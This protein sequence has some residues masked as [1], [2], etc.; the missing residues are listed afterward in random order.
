MAAPTIC[1][2]IKTSTIYQLGNYKP[3][4]IISCSLENTNFMRTAL[5]PLGVLEVVIRNLSFLALMLSVLGITIGSLKLIESAGN[6][7]KLDAGKNIL[8]YSI[9]GLILSLTAPQILIIVFN[10]L[11]YKPP[12]L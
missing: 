2:Q 4:Q 1:D 9:I 12:A 10:V 6:K 3:D 5:S 7:T 11:G 8:L